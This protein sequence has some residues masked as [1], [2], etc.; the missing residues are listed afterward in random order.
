[1][2]SCEEGM[3]NATAGVKVQRGTGLRHRGHGEIPE[4]TEEDEFLL[5]PL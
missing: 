1:M 4:F 3:E 2:L 5:L